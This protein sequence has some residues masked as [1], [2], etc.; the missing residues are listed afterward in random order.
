MS[1]NQDDQV[2]LAVLYLKNTAKHGQVNAGHI[3]LVFLSFMTHRH[4][5]SHLI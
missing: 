5:K 2:L 3:Q 4:L 1:S